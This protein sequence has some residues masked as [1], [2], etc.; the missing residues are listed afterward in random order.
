MSP[1]IPG[2]DPLAQVPTMHLSR[3]EELQMGDEPPRRPWLF[4]W[5]LVGVAVVVAIWL[6]AR[7]AGL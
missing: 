4:R 3:G 6:R 2:D 7:R 1:K 5:C